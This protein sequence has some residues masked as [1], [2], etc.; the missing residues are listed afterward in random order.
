MCF[1]ICSMMYINNIVLIFEIVDMYS[2]CCFYFIKYY[3]C[4]LWD[5]KYYLMWGKGDSF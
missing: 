5:S 1:G 2:Y 4:E 3:K